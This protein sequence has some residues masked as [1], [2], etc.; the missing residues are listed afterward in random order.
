MGVPPEAMP[1]LSTAVERNLINSNYDINIVGQD[2]TPYINKKFKSIVPISTNIVM[3][4]RFFSWILKKLLSSR[5]VVA[6]N[7]CRGCNKCKEHCP[8][9]CIAM[10]SRGKRAFATFDYSKCVRCYCCQ[11]LCPWHCIKVKKP[12]MSGVM[13]SSS[14][15]RARR[16][17][18][19]K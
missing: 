2:I 5:P 14:A 18:K 1:T 8:M 17:N 19:P 7:K 6:K 13:K 16:L 3:K 15:R 10:K 4:N 12:L 11:E 9:K